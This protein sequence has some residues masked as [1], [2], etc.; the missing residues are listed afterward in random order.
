MVQPYQKKTGLFFG[1][2]NPIHNGHLMIANYLAEYTDLEEIWFVV[3]PHNPLKKKQGLAHE[4]DRLEMVHLAIGDDLR[5]RA[6]D[7]ELRLPRPSYTIHTLAY[8]T[9]RYPERRFVLLIGGDNLESLHKW[10]NPEAIL[11]NYELYVY[12]RPG[13]TDGRF[14]GHPS[15]RMLDAPRMEISA[16]LIRQAYAEG[17]NLNYFVPQKVHDYILKKGIYGL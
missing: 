10:K 11:D 9:E 7:I 12:S 14:A 5:F 6:S 1:S 15:I 2:F 3:S 8:L 4:L 13:Y 17:K 16:S